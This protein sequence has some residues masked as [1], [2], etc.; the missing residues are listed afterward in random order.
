MTKDRNTIGSIA[1]IGSS[2]VETI[3][4]ISQQTNTTNNINYNVNISF[5]H[6]K[7]TYSHENTKDTTQNEQSTKRS[8]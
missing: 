8:K 2:V 6:S 5:E 7:R 4:N 3:N 1:S